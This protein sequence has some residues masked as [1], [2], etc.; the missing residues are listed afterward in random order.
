MSVFLSSQRMDIFSEEAKR[1]VQLA[2]EIATGV[3]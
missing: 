1:N 3:K 2:Y